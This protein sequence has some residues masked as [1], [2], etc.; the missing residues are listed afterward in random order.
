MR[1]PSET[2]EERSVVKILDPLPSCNQVY[3]L[4]A[5]LP[6]MISRWTIS[7]ASKVPLK[8]KVTGYAPE[9]ERFT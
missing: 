2:H 3:D 6:D 5:V 4:T 7:H 9:F 8:V 1:A